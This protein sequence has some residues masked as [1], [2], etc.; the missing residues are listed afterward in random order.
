MRNQTKPA[1]NSI[2][3]AMVSVSEGRSVGS[4]LAGA[5]EAVNETLTLMDTVENYVTGPQPPLVTGAQFSAESLV[6][7]A[8]VLNDRTKQLRERVQ[9][10]FN[11]L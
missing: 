10:L 3:P 5:L 2:Q 7:R 1:V 4:Q 6:D 9:Q 11:R 8:T